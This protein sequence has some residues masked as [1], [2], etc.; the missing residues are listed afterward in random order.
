MCDE[1]AYSLFRCE[2]LL[3]GELLKCAVDAPQV[4]PIWGAYVLWPSSSRRRLRL[5]A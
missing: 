1:P 3:W 4:P 2:Q 5:A